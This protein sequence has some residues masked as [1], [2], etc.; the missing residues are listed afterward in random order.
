MLALKLLLTYANWPVTGSSA[1]QQAAVPPSPTFELI[2]SSWPPGMMLNDETAP[3]PPIGMLVAEPKVSATSRFPTRSKV[4][5]KGVGNDG[6]VA[7]DIAGE[8]I[9]P[10]PS[11][12]KT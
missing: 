10:W 8:P 11:T 12:G 4:K 6:K 7:C 2:E 1:I 5:P 9:L 3:L